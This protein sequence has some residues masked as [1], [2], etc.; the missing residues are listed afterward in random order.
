MGMEKKSRV[1][2]ELEMNGL[3][4]MIENESFEDDYDV[5][6]DGRV[7]YIRVSEDSDGC[8]AYYGFDED[9]PRHSVASAYE[10]HKLS[11]GDITL[12]FTNYGNGDICNLEISEECGYTLPEGELYDELV[13][14]IEEVVNSDVELPDD[15]YKQF[16]EDWTYSEIVEEIEDN[17]SSDDY[18]MVEGTIYPA[19]DWEDIVESLFDGEEPD[20]DRYDRMTKHEVAENLASNIDCW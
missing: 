17:L 19:D 13:S 15:G 3:I 1:L 12:E 18:I 14:A 5:T 4:R 6:W 2:S 16:N 20:E 10:D 7:T 8:S 9:G 11:V